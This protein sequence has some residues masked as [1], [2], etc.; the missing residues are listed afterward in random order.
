[1]PNAAFNH[2]L[3]FEQVFQVH[4]YLPEVECDSRS[5]PLV[6][7]PLTMTSFVFAGYFMTSPEH[8]AW[9]QD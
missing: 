3:C 4:L 8:R 5:L 6:G 1:M 9:L 7:S 2:A